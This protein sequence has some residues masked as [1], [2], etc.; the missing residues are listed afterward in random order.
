MVSVK[1]RNSSR[2]V[3]KRS[4]ILPLPCECI[5]SLTNFVV[6]NQE[7]FQ[8]SSAVHS[9]D[10][11]NQHHLPR[12]TDNLSYFQKNAFYAVINI[13][14]NLPSNVKSLINEMAQFK[15]AP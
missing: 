4:D 12:P 6:N 2:G 13:F 1:V 11:R 10:A 15:V 5:F 3:F 7:H 9:I 8:T 14:N